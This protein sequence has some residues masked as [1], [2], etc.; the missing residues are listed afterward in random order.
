MQMERQR[1]SA[2]REMRRNRFFGGGFD[3]GPDED[4]L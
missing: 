1:E 2:A 3:M 4:A